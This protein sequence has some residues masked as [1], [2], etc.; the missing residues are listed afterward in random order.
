MPISARRKDRVAAAIPPR[1]GIALKAQHYREILDGK[2][3]IGFFEVHA[4]NYM[5]AG[6]PPHR[7]L[8]AIRAC[9]PLSLHGVGLSIGAAHDLDGEHLGRLKELVNRYEPGLF[10]EHLAWS[11]HGKGFLNDL[12]PVPYTDETLQ[13]V[14]E[15][16][17]QVQSAI[18]RRMLLENPS[19]Y[20]LFAESVIAET[21]FLRQI[22][23][24]T[25]CG[26]L[27]DVNN[28]QVSAANAE[29][30]PYEYLDSF[31]AEHVAELHLAGFAAVEDDAGERILIDAHGSPVE[32]VVWSLYVH[33]LRRTGPRPT[34]IEWDNDV[35]SWPV[36]YGEAAKAERAIRETRPT[37]SRAAE[38]DRRDD[39]A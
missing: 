38:D 35:P 31:P 23:K 26:L 33:A 16:I 25:G 2:P 7:Y 20:L 10:S 39:A 21:E 17:D 4:E 27:L 29:Y 15:H 37:I 6:G 22:A 19:V 9:Y 1:A 11:T 18:G 3:D 12:L 28:V 8:E 24:R 34:L 5:G 32:P 30:D 14:C 36:L 13:K